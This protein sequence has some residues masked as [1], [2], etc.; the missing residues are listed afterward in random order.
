MTKSKAP[1]KRNPAKKAPKKLPQ[2]VLILTSNKPNDVIEKLIN[3]KGNIKPTVRHA[4]ILDPRARTEYVVEY[5]ATALPE[6]KTVYAHN[7]RS[8]ARQ[9]RAKVD[10]QVVNISSI[11]DVTR[12]LL[13]AA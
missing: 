1:A 13:S 10:I 2:K 4:L 9:L 12:P 11:E 7:C 8:I 5:V 3:A 6:L